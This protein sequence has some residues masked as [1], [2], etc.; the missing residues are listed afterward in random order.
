M[1]VNSLVY[2]KRCFFLQNVCISSSFWS[3]WSSSNFYLCTNLSKKV[4]R[5]VCIVGI[6]IVYVENFLLCNLILL[7]KQYILNYIAPQFQILWELTLNVKFKI[8][9]Y[10]YS[11]VSNIYKWCLI[12]SLLQF[13]SIAV[14]IFLLS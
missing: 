3:N 13:V 4:R 1:I 7:T 9:I 5:L 10:F 6:E 2:L 12:S 14:S 8:F 11:L